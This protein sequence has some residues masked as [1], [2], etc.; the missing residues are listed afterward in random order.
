VPEKGSAE[1]GIPGLDLATIEA[2]AE[3]AEARGHTLLELAISWLLSRRVVAS[4]I[5][6]AMTADQVTANVAASGWPL[7][8]AE[9][10]DVDRAAP[11][12]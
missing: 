5:A 2:L 1:P 11:R 3:L 12:R 9:L 7:T 8:E 10:A 6:G 4:V